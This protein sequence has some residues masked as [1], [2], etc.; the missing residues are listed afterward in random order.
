MKKIKE[1]L[2]EMFSKYKITIYSG[3][4][5]TFLTHFYYFTKRLANEDDLSYLLFGDNAITSGRWNSGTLFTTTLMSPV[6]K[7]LFV[8]IAITLCSI[9][10]CDMFK[11]KSKT[12][13]VLIPLV[14]STFPT[15][16]LSFSYLFMVEVYMV[17]LLLSV[18]AVWVTIKFKYG[19]IIGSLSITFSLGSYQSYISFAVAL[20]II[21]IIREIITK[22]DSKELLK[23]ILKL[24]LMGILGIAFYFLIL[25]IIL[26]IDNLVLSDY[27]GA[28]SMGIPPIS[29][30]PTQIIRTYKHFIGYFLGFSYYR[31]PVFEKIIRVLM[32]IFSLILLVIKIFKEKIY[33][34]KLNFIILIICVITIPLTFNI[35]DFFAYKT[36]LSSL[37]IYYFVCLYV[38]CIVIL[39]NIKKNKLIKYC[40]VILLIIISYVNFIDVNRHYTKLE[41][42]YSYTLNLNN[43]LLT[44]IENTVGYTSETS[45][46]FVGVEGSNFNKELYNFPN[47]ND[48]LTYDQTLWGG[49]YIGYADLYS[50]KNDKKIFKMINYQFGI[51]LIRASDEAR[52]KIINTKEYKKMGTYPN[53]DSIKIIDGILV[54]NF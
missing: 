21:Y 9:L 44:R 46:M 17:S 32:L 40:V 30:W 1:I 8:I 33:S 6:I 38:L 34:N 4:I 41:T 15:L 50:Y 19:F 48:K 3:I 10:I 39:D 26:K 18:F 47:I 2:S 14:L 11:I 5:F 51:N 35:V 24:F 13:K 16:A 25:N 54:V 20:V 45:V 28:N 7:F 23:V 12:N 22:K 52:E 31:I 27:K 36:E 43:R 53:N 37:Q 29:N 42:V 49:K